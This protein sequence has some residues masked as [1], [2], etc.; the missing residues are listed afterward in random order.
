MEWKS[1]SW[2]KKQKHGSWA[3]NLQHLKSVYLQGKYIFREYILALKFY[4]DTTL[5]L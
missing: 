2:V 1:V 4:F 3:L 5:F